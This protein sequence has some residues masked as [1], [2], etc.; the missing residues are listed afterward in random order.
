MTVTARVATAMR[1]FILF[2]RSVL[3]RDS[4]ASRAAMPGFVIS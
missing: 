2:M 4:S 3:R 1:L